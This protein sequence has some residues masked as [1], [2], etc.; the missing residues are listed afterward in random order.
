MNIRIYLYQKNARKSTRRCASLTCRDCGDCLNC[1]D[2]KKYLTFQNCEIYF[3]S[4][5]RLTEETVKT[6]GTLGTV[7]TVETVQRIS[8]HCHMHRN[9]KY[10]LLYDGKV[11][12]Q[13]RN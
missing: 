4:S 2:W 10:L 5:Y 7:E 12:S 11:F 13:L 9:V 8:F 3:N 1:R 6:V